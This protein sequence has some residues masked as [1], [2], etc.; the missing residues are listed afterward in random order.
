MGCAGRES[1]AHPNKSWGRCWLC[2]VLVALTP[3]SS[4]ALP[5]VTEMQSV[6]LVTRVSSTELQ[7]ALGGHKEISV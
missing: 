5:C 3:H 6:G 4:C 2:C 1:L 7:K